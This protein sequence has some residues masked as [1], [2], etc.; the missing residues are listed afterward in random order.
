MADDN[1]APPCLNAL[2]KTQ[3]LAQTKS[4]YQPEPPVET[5]PPLKGKRRFDKDKNMTSA[6]VSVY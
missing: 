5:A 1:A 6:K 3:V 2:N 4:R